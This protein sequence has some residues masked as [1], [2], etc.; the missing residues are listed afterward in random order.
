MQI[1]FFLAKQKIE[2]GQVKSHDH[3]YSRRNHNVGRKV[4]NFEKQ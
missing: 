1:I 3:K 4:E 2:M